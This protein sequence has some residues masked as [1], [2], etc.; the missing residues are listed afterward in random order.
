[1]IVQSPRTGPNPVGVNMERKQDLLLEQDNE[2][3]D[4]ADQKLVQCEAMSHPKNR[5][6]SF[7]S[8]FS[9]LPPVI[10][11]WLII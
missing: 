1:M 7:W 3:Y 10:W 8:W 9:C 11:L 6:T 4:K 2:E 5:D